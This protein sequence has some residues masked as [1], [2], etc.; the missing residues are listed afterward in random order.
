[1]R[2]IR[3]ALAVSAMICVAASGAF[4]REA[5]SHHSSSASKARSSKHSKS[6]RSKG[7]SSKRKSTAKGGRSRS[8]EKK[9]KGLRDTG[10]IDVS[11][12]VWKDLPPEELPASDPDEA[13]DEA[14]P[15]P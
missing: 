5:D 8:A 15:T 11:D 12:T 13:D 6:A 10:D 7:S 14:A 2:I 1:M 9:T 4:A 3:L